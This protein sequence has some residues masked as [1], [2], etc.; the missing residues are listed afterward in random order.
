MFLWVNVNEAYILSTLTVYTRL[1][2]VQ[3]PFTGKHS[4]KFLVK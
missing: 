3:N 4:N 1:I 2:Y